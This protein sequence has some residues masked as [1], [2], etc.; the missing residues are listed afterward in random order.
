MKN[1]P[2]RVLVVDDEADV[3]NLLAELLARRGY[4]VSSVSDYPSAVA[5]IESD[6]P[7]LIIVDLW[8][9]GDGRSGRDLAER[10]RALGIPTLIMSGATAELDELE[11]AGTPVLKKPFRIDGFEAKL[12]EMMFQGL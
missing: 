6:P 4:A 7:H 9:R 11:S 12:A 1:E 10:A 5:A 8:L 3:R 2:P